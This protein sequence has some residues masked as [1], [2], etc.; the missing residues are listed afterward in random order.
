MK[1]PSSIL[2][3]V[4]CAA[5]FGCGSLGNGSSSPSGAT[6]QAG[7]WEFVATPSSGAPPVYIENNLIVAPNQVSS[8]GFNTQLFKFGGPVGGGQFSFCNGWSLLGFVA[9]SALGASTPNGNGASITASGALGPEAS[10]SATIAS[11]G[12]SVSSGSYTDNG[13]FCGLESA[14]TSGT[15]TGYTVVPLNGTFSGTLTGSGQPRQ[16]TIQ[17]VQDSHF[18]ITASG[19][20]VQA[21]VTTA[22]SI[23]PTGTG[24]ESNVIGATFNV[25]GTAINV[26][27]TSMFGVVGHFNPTGTQIA[28]S[29]TDFGVWETGTLTK[30]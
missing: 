13:S 6:M 8:D 15:F 16:I 30:Q 25:G 28:V 14:K 9:N 24:V 18:G 22:L 23:A 29:E 12:Q 5:I 11:S 2:A 4:L 10:F 7:Q 1:H 21:G 17:I 27:G 26:N 20:S 3:L 19:T